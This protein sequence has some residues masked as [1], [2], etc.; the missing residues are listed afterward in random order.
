MGVATDMLVVGA[1]LGLAWALTGLVRRYAEA[2]LLLDHPNQRSSHRVPTPRGGGLAMVVAF[3]GGLFFLALTGRLEWP[4]IAGL[5]GGGLVVAVIGWVDDCGHV[6]ILWRLLTQMLAVALGLFLLGG[7][8]PLAV[9]GWTVPAGPGL[10]LAAVVVLVWLLNLFN[11]MDGIDG[12]AA[13]ESA[14]V[15][16][17]AAAILIGRHGW[18]AA[19]WPLVLLASAS[20]GF[21]VWNWPPARIF[22]GDVGSGFLGYAIGMGAVLT[23]RGGLLPLPVW[24]ILLAVFGV[25]ATFT[26]LARLLAGERWWA[27]HCSHAYQCAARRLG[28][29]RRVTMAALA[30]NV[31]WLWP[32]ARWAE[33]SPGLA[34][35]LVALAVLP[36][37]AWVWWQRA[38]DS[39]FARKKL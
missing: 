10:D 21:L 33:R 32:L 26:L 1:V 20:L 18:Q 19:A 24:L 29:H 7:L 3:A 13:M 23:V 2:R 6:G 15:C 11:F 25:D 17:G 8:P 16:L 28:S 5:G 39:N 4:T 12:L 34:W 31:L 35:R 14:F 9:A 27:P 30:V 37:L 36:V 38:R 22:M